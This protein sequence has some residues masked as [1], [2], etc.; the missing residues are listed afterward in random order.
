M[1]VIIIPQ[2]RSLI[3]TSKKNILTLKY[4]YKGY[5]EIVSHEEKKNG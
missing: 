4:I 5:S 2:L 3:N 1:V